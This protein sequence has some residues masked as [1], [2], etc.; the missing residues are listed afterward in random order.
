MQRWVFTNHIVAELRSNMEVD[1]GI[2]EGSKK[3]K[4][5]QKS[6][7]KY[8]EH[9]VNKCCDLLKQWPPMFDPSIRILLLLSGANAS[10]E[11]KTHAVTQV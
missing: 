1:L 7:M 11:A 6:R 4:D 3:P 10:A 9:M 5:L 8:D 2:K